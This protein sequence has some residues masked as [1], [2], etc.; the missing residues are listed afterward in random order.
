MDVGDSLN[1]AIDIGQV[2]GAFTQGLGLFTMEECVFLK[3]GRLFTTGPGAYK[4]PSVSDIPVELNVTLMDHTPN[5][6]AIFS[7]K[8]S[9]LLVSCMQLLF[10]CRLLVNHHY[11]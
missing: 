6:R 1:P 3:D 8:V 7:S 2:E 4:I 9:C 11:F 10:H 5:P